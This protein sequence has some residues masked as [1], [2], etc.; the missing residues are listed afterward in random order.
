MFSGTSI[1]VI[2]RLL[3]AIPTLLGVALLAFVMANAGTVDP[4]Q[5][6]AGPSASP[7]AIV[8]IRRELGLDKPLYVQFGVYL[9]RLL[10]GEL[11]RSYLTQANVLDE[12]MAVFPYTVE[13]VAMAVA[14]AIAIAIPLG[15]L[16]AVRR[17]SLIDRAAMALSM[18][19]VSFPIFFTGLALQYI[20]AYKLGWFPISGRGG[21]LWTLQGLQHVALPAISL[22]GLITGSLARLTRNAMLEVLGMDY[23]RTARA[24]GVSEITILF[25]HALRN[26]LLPVVTMIGL[27]VGWLLG[28]AVVTETIFAW[29]GIGRV[30]VGAI[31]NR[32]LPLLQGA[33]II[34]STC[35]VFVNLIVDVLHVVLNPRIRL[36]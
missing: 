9:G 7:E 10:Q 16:S 19:G 18:T 26:A 34:G 1:Y 2:R 28:G 30:A 8:S 22:T 32:D 4:A 6:L 33:V 5:M 3:L 35:Y 21:P 24:K 36:G 15:V 27:Q 11:G 25:K 17:G 13:L 23:V 20:F 14:L 31:L 12:I 29:P